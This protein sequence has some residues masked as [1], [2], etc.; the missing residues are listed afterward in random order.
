MSS[1]PLSDA[2]YVA[3]Q[4]QCCPACGQSEIE[5]GSVPIEGT[6]AVQTVTCNSCDAEWT[7]VYRLQGYTDLCTG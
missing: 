2:E 1:K 6:T 7:D 3:K 5:G 4:G